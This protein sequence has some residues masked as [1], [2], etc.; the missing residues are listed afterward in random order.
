MASKSK[1]IAELLNGDTTVTA[2]DIAAGSIDLDKLSA[3][4]TKDATTYLRGDNTFSALS[5]TLAGLD[6]T[7]VDA[8]DPTYTENI[9]GA[10]V[11]HLWVNSTSGEV[12][13]LTDA[14]A[15]LNVWTN[16]GDGTGTIDASYSAELFLVA[17]GGGGGATG[18]GSLRS[19]AGGG[20]GGLIDLAS[21]TL[22]IGNSYT[23]TVGAGG[24]GG[25]PATSGDDSIVALGATELQRAIGGGGG[26]GAGGGTGIS[27]GSGGGGGSGS[28]TNAGG[29][30]TSGQ[31]NAGGT[32][33]GNSPY[34]GGGG[35]GKGG[36]GGSYSAPNGGSSY[37]TT[38]TG[39]T[40]DYAGGGGGGGDPG[41]AGAGG[42]AGAGAGGGYNASIAN[43]GS[44]GGGGNGSSNNSGGAGSSGQVIIRYL[45]SQRG[46]GGTVTSHGGYTLHTF[47]SSDTYTA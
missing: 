27:G 31:G 44:G 22:L 16:I 5:T 43:R 14:T 35:G 23:V 38:F 1:N 3:T 12:F 21:A 42:G 8:S 32:G 19:G 6:D 40:V 20:A 37:S 47:N 17:G 28:G 34:R 4:G 26:Q 46:T 33:Y 11:G 30:G 9:S 24:A 7:T 25:A 41:S 10:S 39:S 18:S 13:V 29:A 45:G 2:N 36:V 15:N